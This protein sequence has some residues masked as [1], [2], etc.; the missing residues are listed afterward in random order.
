MR[1]PL[2]HVVA[3][4]AAGIWS[5]QYIFLSASTELFWIALLLLGALLLLRMDFRLYG[6]V[7]ALAG[8]FLCGAFLAA[9]EHS[10]LPSRH[11]EL[12]VQSGLINLKHAS[13]VTGWARTPSIPRPGGEYFDLQITAISQPQFT[14]PAQGVIR[15]Y[16]YQPRSGPA[17]LRM[18]Y[19]AQV[20]INVPDLRH[21]RNYKTLGAFDYE[22]Y[23]RR[24]GI[25]LTGIV[26][27]AEDVA[28]L[29]GREGS[30]LL[31]AVYALRTRLDSNLDRMFPPENSTGAI[32]KAMLL[33]DDNWLPPDVLTAFQTSGTYHLLVVSGLHAGALALGLLMLLKYSRLAS[34]LQT[35]IVLVSLIVYTLLANARIPTLRAALMIS[36]YLGA[37]L[38]YRER[39]L[40][41]SVAAAALILLIFHPS[42]LFDSGFQ[43]SFTAVLIIAAIAAPLVEWTISPYRFALVALDERERD[44]HLQP[45]QLQFR[46]DVRVLRDFVFGDLG[47]KLRDVL[48]RIFP[49][50]ISGLLAFAEAALAVILMQAGLAIVM[51]IYF[52]RVT[53]SGIAANLLLLPLASIIVPLGFVVLLVSLL[54][55]PLA[56]AGAWT[57]GLLVALLQSIV[58][59]SAQLPRLD[60][61]VAEPPEALTYGFFVVLVAIAVLALRRS[62]LVWVPVAALIS[63]CIALTVAPYSRDHIAG[64]LEITALDVG[65]G[66][67]LYISFPEG[68]TMLV[69]G[70]GVIPVPGS[71]PPRFDTG[72]EIVSPFLWAHR[73]NRVDVIMLTH[74]HADHLRGLIKIIENFRVGELWLGPGPSGAGLE[75]LLSVARSHGIPVVRHHSGERAVIDG[76]ELL[77]LSPPADWNPKRVSNNDSLVVRLGYGKRHILLAGDAEARMERL[78][79]ADE[80]PLASDVLKVGHH[81]SKTST[82]AAFLNRVAPRFGIISVGPYGR[83]GHPNAEVL[84]ALSGVGVQTYRTD[85]DGSVTASTDGNRVEFSRFRDT[86]RPWPAFRVW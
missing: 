7:C 25:S 59:W 10:V 73:V 57:L 62:R 17:S 82:T 80:L 70:G 75:R 60:R 1:N 34:W 23:M 38:I 3:T 32:L 47:R 14:G 36:I 11:V 27:K 63:L 48:R 65:Q 31:S 45:T 42:D 37:R 55:F 30:P 24:Q 26:R 9:E 53:W 85:L 22:S 69:D 78:M 46:Q 19:G 58:H 28:L 43:L 61:R 54:W 52:H 68:R 44:F 84:D 6:L 40:L 4:F 5:A 72:E 64:K 86:V 33:G 67:S 66:D 29:P 2:L 21:P 83:F 12:L 71:P 51:S 56:T 76:V 13:R 41:N 77:F 15:F 74:A 16:Y 20:A 39:A 35:L 81:G 18:P 50:T 49:R 79:A 8:V